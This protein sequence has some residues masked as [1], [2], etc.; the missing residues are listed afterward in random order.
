MVTYNS[1]HKLEIPDCFTDLSNSQAL[2]TILNQNQTPIKVKIISNI[3]VEIYS[4]YYHHIHANLNYLNSQ[5]KIILFHYKYVLIT[6]IL[7]KK[8][9]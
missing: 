2:F 7:N 5:K 1:I 6:S 3:N 4:T 9:R 8:L